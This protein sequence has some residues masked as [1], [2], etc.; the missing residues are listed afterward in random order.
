MVRPAGAVTGSAITMASVAGLAVTGCSAAVA[1]LTAVVA[2]GTGDR[3]ACDVRIAPRRSRGVAS[4]LAFAADAGLTAA[5]N[6]PH[7]AVTRAG[8]RPAV[9]ERGSGDPAGGIAA[10]VRGLRRRA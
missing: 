7:C 10:V 8:R 1:D 9:A 5:V 3:A 4:G 6:R 2:V